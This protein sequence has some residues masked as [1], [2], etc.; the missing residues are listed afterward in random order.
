MKKFLFL[1]LVL[2]G[3]GFFGVKYFKEHKNTPLNIVPVAT[4]SGRQCFAYHQIATADAPYNVDEYI[5]I[6]TNGSEVTGTKKGTQSGPD[7][8]NGYVG[9]ISGAVTNEVL[10]DVYS[11]VIESSS[12]KEKE[13]YK[14]TS[15]GLVKQR[16][17]LK[18]EG[19]ILVPDKTQK[20]VGEMAYLPVIC[21]DTPLETESTTAGLNQGILNNGI[22]LTP[23]EVVSDSRCPTDVKCIW[24]GTV[25]LRTL[26]ENGAD[27]STVNLGLGTPFSFSGKSVTLTKVTPD[28]QS[29]KTISQ[30]QYKF[31][32]EVK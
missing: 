9:G 2:A 31:E 24:A 18:E 28:K 23:L 13:E 3:L 16:Y 10:T 19:G 8:T 21:N 29:Q 12:N 17:P 26:L 4:L 25:T 7:M 14:I 27:S 5:D 30:S 20:L 11:Y 6:N 22:H 1:I 32:F 15:A